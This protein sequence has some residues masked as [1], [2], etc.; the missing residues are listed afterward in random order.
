VAMLQ[1][2][3]RSFV[4]IALYLRCVAFIALHY[5]LYGFAAVRLIWAFF[6]ALCE[7]VRLGSCFRCCAFALGMRSRSI[8]CLRWLLAVFVGALAW[9]FG[10]RALCGKI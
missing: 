3:A 10:F 5:C 1:E 4:L 6:G 2:V 7:V 8:F 9:A